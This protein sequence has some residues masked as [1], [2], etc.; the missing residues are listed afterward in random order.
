MR[1]TPVSATPG[2]QP[3]RTRA[4]PRT[5]RT[6]GAARQIKDQRRGYA[7]AVLRSLARIY[8]GQPTPAVQRVLGDAF[9]PLGVRLPAATLHT[10]AVE[11]TAGRPVELP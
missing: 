11:I 1:M 9:K 2:T 3:P 7:S 8:R 10:L 4:T 5:R 6:S